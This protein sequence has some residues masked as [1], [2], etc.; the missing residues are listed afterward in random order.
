MRLESVIQSLKLSI[1]RTNYLRCNL[2][3]CFCTIFRELAKP[4]H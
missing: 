3:F 2:A 1:S 4:R